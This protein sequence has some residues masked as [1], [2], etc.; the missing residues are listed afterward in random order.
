MHMVAPKTKKF[1]KHKGLEV[2]GM[3]GAAACASTL[4]IE[5]KATGTI[6]PAPNN[7]AGLTI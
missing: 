6:A 1:N 3:D 4:P 2:I 5:E 7:L